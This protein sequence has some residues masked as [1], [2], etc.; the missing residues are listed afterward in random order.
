MAAS[1]ERIDFIMETRE[2]RARLL[3]KRIQV[4]PPGAVHQFN[5]DSESRFADGGKINQSFDLFKIFRLR[6]E[7]LANEGPDFRAFHVPVF[8]LQSRDI[9]FELLCPLCSGR[10][11]IA[12]REF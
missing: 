5:C 8:G 12:G 9:R 6:I 2:A 4:T 1:E 3:Q 7:C 10:R 11:P